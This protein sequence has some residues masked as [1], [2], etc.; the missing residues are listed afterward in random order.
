MTGFELDIWD[1][2]P[3]R[4]RSA[5]QWIPWALSPMIRRSEL[6]AS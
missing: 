3:G 4:C 5:M 6:E 1:L 2:L